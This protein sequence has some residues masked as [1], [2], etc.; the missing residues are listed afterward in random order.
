MQCVKNTAELL[1]SDCARNRSVHVDFEALS[2]A[3]LRRGWGRII[4]S[5]WGQSYR[6]PSTTKHRRR[7][8]RM[9][10][11]SSNY[12]RQGVTG[13][14]VNGKGSSVVMFIRGRGWCKW[15]I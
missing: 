14:L 10:S 8:F 9:T 6:E 2:G 4:R 1:K 11:N 5:G 7:C 3:N 15:D 13:R 12:F